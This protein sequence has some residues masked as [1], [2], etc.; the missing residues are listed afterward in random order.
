MKP[1]ILLSAVSLLTAG[2]SAADNNWPQWRG[3]QFNGT[4]PG[5]SP[6]TAFSETLNLKWKARIP[7]SG[8][9][10]PIV[11]GDKI[12]IQTAIPKGK[13]TTA[14]AA[15][16]KPNEPL[17]PPPG[18]GEGRL[19]RGG[20]GMRGEKPTDVYQFALLCL[21]RASGKEIWQK[22]VR[23]ELPHEG[24]HRDHGFSSHSPVADGE[25]VYAWFGSRGLHCLDMQGNV[26]WSKDL[27]KLQTRNAFGEGNSPAL[28]G[29]VV[30]INWDHEGEDFIAA[31]NKKDGKELWRQ[32]RSEET[33]WTTPLIVEAG[34]KKQVIVSATNKIRSYELE[35][36][37]EIWSCGGMTGN[38]VPTP[39]AQ[40]GIFYAISGFRGAA[41]LAIR[42]DRTGDLTDSDAIA[43]KHNKRTPYVPSPLLTGGRLYFHSG[44]DAYLSIF[45][46]KDGKP[47]LEAERVP[48]MSGI[49]SS[50]V[51]AGGHIYLTG[52]DGT[53]VVV[54]A[55]DKLEIVSTNKLDEA[56]EA[57]PAIAG[58]DLILRGHSAVYCFGAK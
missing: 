26:K 2:I 52:R 1:S 30:V 39:V 37:K 20:G 6:P 32:A 9:S 25:H 40:D 42:L 48:G 44:N 57:S 41:L 31:F 38:V 45:D 22:V 55:G 58:G 35:N 18:P 47:L 17:P 23:E 7:G 54:K 34:G 33:T 36:G 56:F 12:F 8:A 16:E 19:R 49:Y 29:H 4:A 3:P 24:H 10:T 28:S 13:K 46:A 14:P 43:W 51:A 50:P 15:E 11:W 5:A 53:V 27:G 21:D